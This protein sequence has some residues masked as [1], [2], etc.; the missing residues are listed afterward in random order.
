MYNG[1]SRFDKDTR[2]GFALAL[3]TALVLAAPF[4]PSTPVASSELGL[5]IDDNGPVNVGAF[6]SSIVPQCESA[7]A[8]KKEMKIQLFRKIR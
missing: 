2:V 4:A 1:K 3:V 6:K 5:S 7:I 8:R